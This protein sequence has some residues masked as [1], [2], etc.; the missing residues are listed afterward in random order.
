MKPF[1]I[2]VLSIFIFFSQ[3]TTDKPLNNEAVRKEISSREIKRITEAEIV[4]KV[5]EIGS[6]I[7]LATKKTL[8]K[9]LQNAMMNG[10]VENAISYC[11]LN[12]MPLVDSLSRT[13]EAKIRRVSM[14]PRNSDDYPDDLENSILEAY[15]Y[16]WKD[17][18][19]LKTNVQSIDGGSY[20]FTKPIF[21]DN[22]LCL[23]CHGSKSNGLSQQTHDFIKSKYPL[24]KAIGYS[25]GDLRG[26][27]SITIPK[28]RVIQSF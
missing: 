16:Q 3:C 20:L 18:I 11:N 17:S 2:W 10:G 9:N 22:G 24:D 14:K 5:H 28:K 6:T 15:D 7:A 26:M 23:N 27:W 13:F 19:E 4:G 25:I 12:A 21:I 1:L 8:G